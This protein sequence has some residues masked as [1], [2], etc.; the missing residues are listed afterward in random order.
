M[1]IRAYLLTGS[2]L[3]TGLI[4]FAGNVLF[5]LLLELYGLSQ[6]LYAHLLNIIFIFYGVNRILRLN[7]A[8]G[9]NNFLLNAVSAATT[10]FVGVLLSLAALLVYF[11]AKGGDAY[12]KLLPQHFMAAGESSVP[13]YIL[14]LLFEGSASCIGGTAVMLLYLHSSFKSD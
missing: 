7:I 11:Y 14:C 13:L 10:S 5:F 3:S 8:Q 12:V 9:Q 4:I 2:E 1:R 6:I